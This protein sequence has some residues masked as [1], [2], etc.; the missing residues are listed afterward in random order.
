[1]PTPR[2]VSNFKAAVMLVVVS[3][4][5]GGFGWYVKAKD[6]ETLSIADAEILKRTMTEITLYRERQQQ[7]QTAINASQTEQNT[8]IER[9]CKA[10][11]APIDECLVDVATRTV[12]RTAKP[13]APA[14]APPA[15]K[16]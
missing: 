2:Q 15:A 3:T 4:A 6:A 10:I 8:V 13:P 14:S 9:V 1:M 12:K 5:M 11:G 16:K 7:I